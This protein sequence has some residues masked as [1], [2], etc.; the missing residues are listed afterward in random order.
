MPLLT[1]DYVTINTDFSNG[2]SRG[3]MI[4]HVNDISQDGSSLKFSRKETNPFNSTF[5]LNA[6]P[7]NYKQ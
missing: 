7:S 5:Q 4:G 6:I 1:G 3:R 2:E